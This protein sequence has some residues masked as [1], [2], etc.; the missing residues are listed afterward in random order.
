[1]TILYDGPEPK[2]INGDYPDHTYELI[3]CLVNGEQK[4]ILQDRYLQKFGYTKEKYQ[5]EFANAPVKSLMA[6]DNYRRAAL[7]DGG[8]RSRNM[9]EIRKNPEISEK[10]I[11]TRRIFLD[12]DDSKEYREYLSEKA[13]RQHAEHGLTDSA[14][15][16]FTSTYQGSEHQEKKRKMF[17]EDNPVYRPG[18]IDKMKE[19]YIRNHDAGLHDDPKGTKKKRYHDT[20]LTYQSSYELDFLNYCEKAGILKYVK[21]A[22]TM[23][24]ALYPKKYYLPDYLLF[25]EYIVE[26]K[27]W[28]IEKLGEEKLG[29][30]ILQEKRAL[31]ERSG[32]KWLYILEKDYSELNKIVLDSSVRM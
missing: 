5:S 15:A 7:N 10:A 14:R 24:D 4:K 31:V 17:L 25:D 13:K 1:M 8:V 12:S 21:N 29:V 3:T 27:S 6:S 11:K 18:I 30:G 22:K 26:I 9:K 2:S 28:Y 32:F 16:Y 23:R 19:T 20:G